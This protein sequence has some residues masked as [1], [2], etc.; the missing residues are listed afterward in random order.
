MNKKILFGLIIGFFFLYK[1]EAQCPNGGA[2]FVNEIYNETGSGTEYVELVV[3]GDPANPTAPVNLEGWIIDDNNINQAGQGTATG[4]LKLDNTF[5]SVNP[6]AI[7]L[8]YNENFPYPGLPA[9]NPPWLY[10]VAGTD[11]DGCSSSPNTTNSNYTPCGTPG[12]SYNYVLMAN[13]GDIMQTRNSSEGFYHALRYGSVNVMP[14]VTP[15]EV[16]DK[17]IGLDCGDWF[18]GNNYTITTQTPGEANSTENQILINA[19]KNG[20]LDCNNINSSCTAP[21]PEINGI[22][23]NP[24]AMCDYEDFNVTATGLANMGQSANLDKDFGIDFVYFPGAAPP[25]DAYSGGTSLGTVPY[26]GLT[27]TDPNQEASL[28]VSSGTMSP[29]TYNICA[30]LDQE[31]ANNCNPQQCEVVEIFQS[32]VAS[33]DGTTVFCPGDCNEI[34]TVIEGGTEPYDA[35]FKLIVG[36]ISLPFT[37]PAYDVNNQLT[38]CYSGNIFPYYDSGENTLYVPLYI[39]GSGT[40]LLTDLVDDN[41]CQAQSI[42]PDNMTLI[43]KEDLDISPAGPLEECDYDFDGEATFDLTVLDNVLKNGAG[44]LTANWYE[45]QDCTTAISDPSAFTTPT[46]TVYVFLSDDSDDKCNSDTLPVDLIVIDIPNPGEDNFVEVCNTE[47]CFN[48]LYNLGGTPEQGG[49]WT[50]NDNS[51]VDLSYPECVDFTTLDKGTYTFTY[52]TEDAEGKCDAQSATLTI[53]VSIPGNPG[54]DGDDT[55]CGAPDDL[56]DLESYLGNDYDNNGTWS[57]NDGFDISDPNNVDMS[58]ASAGTYYFYY[59]IENYPCDVQEAIVT[60][61]ILQIPSAGNDSTLYI[62]YRGSNS[63]QSLNDALGIHDAN[64]NWYDVDTSGVDLSDPDYVDFGGLS[65]DT[66]H[67][68]YVIED[69]GICP[70]DDALI[71]VIIEPAPFAGI[72]GAGSLCVG[73]TDTINLYEYL[74]TS[75]DSTGIWIQTGGDSV[76]IS[77]PDTVL[78]NNADVGIDSFMYVTSGSC[79]HDTAFVFIDI[80]ASPYAGDDY[81]YSVCENSIVNLFDSLKNYNIGG[82]WID[83]N[84]DTISDPGN[85][86]LDSAG[87]YKYLYVLPE[88][89]TC[90]GDTAIGIITALAAP[91][92]GQGEDFSVCQNS[93]DFVNLYDYISGYSQ[94]GGIWNDYN[95]NIIVNPQ[96]YS[97]ASYDTGQYIIRYMLPGNG[98]CNSDTA[99]FTVFIVSSPNA[100][101]DNNFVVCNSDINNIVNLDSLLGTHNPIGKWT[102]LDNVNIDM[103]NTQSID[104]SGAN[105]GIFRFEYKI[106]KNGSC[107]ADSALVTVEVKKKLFAGNDKELTFCENGNLIINIISELTPDAGTLYIIEDIDQTGAIDENS[108]EI[109]ISKLNKGKYYFNLITGSSDLCGTDTAVLTIT[110]VEA[111]QAG[112]DN[113]IEVCNNET[114]VELNS[115]LGTHDIGGMWIDMDNSGVDVQS[116]NGSDVSF[117][118]VVAGI[119]RYRYEIPASG[120]CPES[121]AIITVTVNPVTTFDFIKEICPG[122]EFTIGN[123]IYNLSNPTGTEYFTNVFGCDSIVFINLTEK[124]TSSEYFKNDENCFELGKFVLESL[125]G[126]EMPVVLIIHSLDSFIVDNVPYTVENIPGGTYGFYIRDNAGCEISQDSFTIEDFTPYEINIEVTTTPDN[127]V[128]NVVTDI[129][130]QTIKWNPVNGLSCDNCLNVIATPTEDTQYIVTLIDSEGCTVSD[131]IFL[132]GIIHKE[133]EKINIDIPNI[134]TPDG[135][136]Y[137][138]IF[139]AKSNKEGSTYDMYIYDRWGEKVFYAKGLEFND[140]VNGWD[141]NF[142]GEK[143]LPG[144]YVYMIIV[145]FSEGNK[146][147]FTGDLLLIR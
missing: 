21:C 39:T 59:D 49:Q 53:D 37:I 103:S 43:F 106:D 42:D 31:S 90:L 139:Y 115:L 95:G 12:G 13:S 146:E 9:N 74:G 46:T 132:T 102:N 65:V 34:N 147:T 3:V 141:G 82:I 36:F 6:G 15:A 7:I 131:T 84:N 60:I 117:E 73:S 54:I 112:N 11:I 64:G 27:G 77:K 86:S 81:G 85:I 30:I 144:V 133:E 68:S 122:Q 71:T 111:L 87:I 62:C 63:I 5:N 28:S 48:L 128:L 107:P 135:D 145:N 33:L 123:N 69:D 38:I 72:D 118:N 56:I 108:G 138:E 14:D 127:Y 80:T 114:N 40:L 94:S 124:E 143:A 17:S 35:S 4:H 45:D 120:T 129:T 100:G 121:S 20:T 79:G 125:S 119:Y 104:F 29:G 58:G 8:I 19:I 83:N 97:F 142:K 130:P 136:G 55:F 88:N 126:A 57:N 26:S 2:I 10:V 66:F 16:S 32:P 23:I 110:I 75:F 18:D 25:A 109:D 61:Y 41:G 101:N 51:G 47:T 24:S 140:S 67:Y 91:E 137:N 50:D 76:D 134:F 22:T 113:F 92:A 96:N 116:S 78:F 105:P 52:T 89:G 70:A 99:E 98:Y 93:A 1:L 44:G